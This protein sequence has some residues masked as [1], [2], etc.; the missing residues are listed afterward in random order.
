MSR[1]EDISDACKK[2]LRKKEI[3]DPILEFDIENKIA[4]LNG[5]TENLNINPKIEK[6]IA[7]TIPEITVDNQ[8]G[9]LPKE[10]N[11]VGANTGVNEYVKLDDGSKVF[12]AEGLKTGV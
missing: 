2:I 3:K 9:F 4:T 5:I 7:K 12:K 6:V 10:L 11:I 8:S 1:P